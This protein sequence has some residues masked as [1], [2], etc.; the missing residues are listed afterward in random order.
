MHSSF[1]CQKIVNR[2]PE[3]PYKRVMHDSSI[4]SLQ[5]SSRSL[6]CDVCTT[7]RH[8]CNCRIVVFCSIRFEFHGH[9]VIDER[10]VIIFYLIKLG[11][12]LSVQ[13]CHDNLLF[14]CIVLILIPF[15]C[16]MKPLL[17]S[18]T[19]TRLLFCWDYPFFVFRK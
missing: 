18:L 15:K 6:A 1:F 14:L 10:Q 11:K 17:P 7:V 2:Q 5:V 12:I 8:H 19:L 3:F 4:L 9:A 13:V 16:K